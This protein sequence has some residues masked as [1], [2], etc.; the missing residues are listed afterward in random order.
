MDLSRRTSRF[1]II[2]RNDNV[3]LYITLIVRD[4]GALLRSEMFL[5]CVSREFSRLSAGL[6]VG[7]N[8]F[9]KVSARLK[10]FRF[11]NFGTE[12]NPNSTSIMTLF[13]FITAISWTT[14]NEAFKTNP[15]AKR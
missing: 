5:R 2:S 9:A 6:N 14:I 11:Q 7:G 15:K 8:E 3:R 13:F 4:S 1:N 12:Y 10:S